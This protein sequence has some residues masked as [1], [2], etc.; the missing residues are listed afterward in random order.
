MKKTVVRYSLFVRTKSDN[1]WMRVSSRAYQLNLARHVYMNRIL[2]HALGL[3]YE[4]YGEMRLR[5]VA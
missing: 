2:D 5:K 3:G 4:H 1:G